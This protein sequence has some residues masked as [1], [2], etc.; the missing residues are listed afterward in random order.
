[1]KHTFFCRPN[2]I[3]SLRFLCISLILLFTTT[4]QS[5]Q[6][7]TQQPTQSSEKAAAVGDAAAKAAE[8]KRRFEEQK[9][10]LEE[11]EGVLKATAETEVNPDQT[12]F[13]SPSVTNMLPGEFREFCAFDIDGKI[14]TGE[15]EWTIDDQGVATLNGRGAPT[16]TTHRSG[17][18]T[19]RARVG[20][21]TA[22]A[23]ITVLEGDKL[24]DGTIQWSVPSYPGYKSKQ[25]VQAVP[26]ANG[27]DLYTMEENDQGH[28]LIRA[29][30]SEGIFLWQRKSNQ[31]I[32]NAV[33]H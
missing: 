23:S 17:K 16:V 24:P 10:K 15:A 3:S 31:K 18:A 27:P 30:T 1:M 26:S 6:R 7:W 2:C 12:L 33:P 21:R 25:I 11:S 13:V 20:G 8:R 29:W 22:E 4:I 5:A 28:S 14:L 19:L 32:V 9:Q